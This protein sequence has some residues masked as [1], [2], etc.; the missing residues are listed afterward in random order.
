MNSHLNSISC[1]LCQKLVHGKD[2]YTDHL[3]EDH[4]VSDAEDMVEMY[5]T[6]TENM[7]EVFEANLQSPKDDISQKSLTMKLTPLRINVK[8]MHINNDNVSDDEFEFV[9]W[10]NRVKYECLK[11]KAT[12]F[13]KSNIANHLRNSHKICKKK[14]I[15][16][17]YQLVSK[18]DKYICKLCNSL[19]KMEYVFIKYH[20][21]K[22]HKTKLSEYEDIHEAGKRFDGRCKSKSII[23]PKDLPAPE[24]EAAIEAVNKS[25]SLKS[26]IDI[27][28]GDLP[29][30]CS[31]IQW[32]N[33][34]K[35]QCNFCD[36]ESIGHSS[37]KVHIKTSYK[38][39]SAKN[40]TALTNDLY[41]CKI[42]ER[43]IKLN[44]NSVWTHVH[45][46]HNLKLSVYTKKY[47]TSA[48][49]DAKE[50][51]KNMKKT[52]KVVLKDEKEAEIPWH[53]R[54]SLSCNICSKEIVGYIGIKKHLKKEHGSQKENEYTQ[55]N[56][57]K[58]SCKICSMKMR[59]GYLS[60]FKHV[61]N[62]HGMKFDLYEEQYEN[63]LEQN[64]Q[65]NTCGI[66]N[67]TV[68][69]TPSSLS[70]HMR[71]HH[72]KP[73]RGKTTKVRR[74]K[75]LA[76]SPFYPQSS[77]VLKAPSPLPLSIPRSGKIIIFF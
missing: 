66:C 22:E 26:A 49:K 12:V 62:V 4:N 74:L 45:R 36:H 41:S 39:K 70:R 27:F 68:K 33:K 55:L 50:S 56:K 15:Q 65:K 2:L 10:F 44:C 42:C 32:Y 5:E 19:L 69:Q 21:E 53:S 38:K 30:P 72:K 77:P 75:Q 54:V 51:K 59:L 71:K 3:L 35:Y 67:N 57:E 24:K 63:C 64:V 73:L 20:L 23:G 40:Y 18:D 16:R 14:V 60:V 47:E 9:S 11:C 34:V 7:K 43:K 6:S 17:S 25:K 28:D 58:Y 46:I 13:G 31:G 61:E 1:F 52:G 76:S 29:S 8:D 37:I 48:I